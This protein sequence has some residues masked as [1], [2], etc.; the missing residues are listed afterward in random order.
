MEGIAQKVTEG[1]IPKSLNKHLS[2]SNHDGKIE[3]HYKLTDGPA[4]M[5]YGA[6]IADSLG[7]SV[8]NLRQRLRARA[9]NEGFELGG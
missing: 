1:R 3:Y 6:Q 2:F 5:D 9:Q 7:L 8:D 4:E